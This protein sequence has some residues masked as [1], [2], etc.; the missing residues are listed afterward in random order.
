MDDFLDFEEAADLVAQLD[1]FFVIATGSIS[2][3]VIFIFS[4]MFIIRVVITILLVV[5]IVPRF[6]VQIYQ[7]FCLITVVG[8]IFTLYPH[9]VVI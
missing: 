7:F 3:V 5:S 2:V 4:V 6:T 1:V 8:S 9:T